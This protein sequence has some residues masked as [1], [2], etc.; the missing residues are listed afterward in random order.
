MTVVKLF[1]SYWFITMTSLVFSQ[2]NLIIEVTNIKKPVGSIRVGLFD[3]D[4]DFLKNAKYGE[5]VKATADKVIVTFTDLPPG[6]YGIS[7]IHDENEN[8]KLDTNFMGVPKE[9]FGFGNNAMGSFGP[10]SFEKAKIKWEGKE[11][12]IGVTVKYF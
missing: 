1:L 11:M 6:E 9:G 5:V 3:S 8:G 7:V 2:E 12:R 10:P 4:E